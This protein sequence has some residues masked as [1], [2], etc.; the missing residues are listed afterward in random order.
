MAK[1]PASIYDELVTEFGITPEIELDAEFKKTFVKSQVDEI[2]KVLWRECVDYI[3]S[4]MMAEDKD[5][6]VATAGASKKAEKK[7]NIKQFV[8]ALS[9]YELLVADLEK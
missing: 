9:S 6:V 1:T 2:K 8:K 5:E 3:I 4:S 7:N